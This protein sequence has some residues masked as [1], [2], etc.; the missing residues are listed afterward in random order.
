MLLLI[1]KT[2]SI[3]FSFYNY[4]LIGYSK[5]IL[6]KKKIHSAP[7]IKITFSNDEKKA[8]NQAV[9]HPEFIWV[10]CYCGLSEAAHRRRSYIKVFWKH[11]VNLQENTLYQSVIS[12]KL[13][14]N[15]LEITLRHGC[16]PVNL[17]HNFRIP[18]P[19]NTFGGMLL[20][21]I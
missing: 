21:F 13:Q 12:I 17:L 8:S 6:A 20:A 16:A 1:L 3:I 11:V 19:D 7:Q 5:S 4:H 18:F 15:F 10:H 14:N 9:T 2:I